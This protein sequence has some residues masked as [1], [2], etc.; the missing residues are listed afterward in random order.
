MERH[1]SPVLLK[2]RRANL[3][4]LS[5]FFRS[6]LPALIFVQSKCEN[7]LT[8]NSSYFCSL[9]TILSHQALI[10][11]VSQFYDDKLSG[12]FLTVLEDLLLKYSRAQGHFLKRL[13]AAVFGRSA[14]DLLVLFL[15][16]WLK[17]KMFVPLWTWEQHK[18]FEQTEQRSLVHR[19]ELE[20]H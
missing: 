9:C 12:R 2:S 14:L 17:I 18:S 7:L 10:K 3:W 11:A 1:S 15:N 8:R 5:W 13:Y 19:K 16:G 4:C 20:N 6:P